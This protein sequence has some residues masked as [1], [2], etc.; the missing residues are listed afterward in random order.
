MSEYAHSE[1]ICSNCKFSSECRSKKTYLGGVHSCEEY[2]LAESTQKI[3]KTT[4][5]AEAPKL[6]TLHANTV[7]KDPPRPIKGLC[8]NCAHRESCG[9][10]RPESGVWYCEEYE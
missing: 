10:P 5:V 8:S 6:N 4:F 9:L 3:D 1:G 2:E 7:E